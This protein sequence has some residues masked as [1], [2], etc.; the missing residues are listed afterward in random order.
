[1]SN[2]IDLSGKTAIVTGAGQ[3][4][5]LAI[6]LKLASAGAKIAVAEFNEE[7]GKAAVQQI[8]GMGVKSSFIKTDVR[9]PQNVEAMAAAVVDEF[10]KIDILVNNAGIVKNTPAEDTPDD[11]WRSIIDVNLNGVYWCCRAVGKRMLEQGYGSIVN[12]ASMSGLVSNKPQ[13]QAAYNSSKA[14]V[15]ML[16]R[17]LAGE[18]S[19]RGL[20]INSV[21]PGYIGTEL[22]QE[23]LKQSDEWRSIWHSM[24]PMGRI[25]EPE[26]VAKA[27]LFLASDMATYATGTNLVIDGGYTSW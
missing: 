19:G 21:S 26:D 18:W 17:S 23:V 20:R 11:V 16:T 22:V 5:G 15:F 3:G 2:T 13:P 12:V 24:T 27:V 8:E 10:G 6:A 14:A 9:D 7:S 4:I 1:M 25:G